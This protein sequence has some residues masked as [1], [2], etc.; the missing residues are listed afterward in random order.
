M[1]EAFASREDAEMM[2][3][4]GRSVTKECVSKPT[5]SGYAVM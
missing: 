1:S 5:D 4:C 3:P 2:P